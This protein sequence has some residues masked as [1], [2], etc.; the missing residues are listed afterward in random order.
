MHV[1]TLVDAPRRRGYERKKMEDEILPARR[2]GPKRSTS[3]LFTENLLDELQ[4]IADS[5]E[6]SRNELMEFLLWFAVRKYK[7]RKAR[8]AAEGK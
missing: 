2:K 1:T 5:E 7:E 6:V 8:E 4:A 3:V